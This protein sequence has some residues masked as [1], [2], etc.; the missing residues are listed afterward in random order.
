MG[1]KKKVEK[2]TNIVECSICK[3]D[4][5]KY[6][7]GWLWISNYVCQICVDKKKY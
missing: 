1:R 5:D 4:F 3:K 2:D 7:Q 6:V